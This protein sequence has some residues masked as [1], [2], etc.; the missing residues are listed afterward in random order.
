MKVAYPKCSLDYRPSK[1]REV[2]TEK[3]GRQSSVTNWSAWT[4]RKRPSGVKMWMTLD[5]GYGAVSFFQETLHSPFEIAGGFGGNHVEHDGGG[6]VEEA[7][8]GAGG[9]LVVEED[10]EA[11][12]AGFVVRELIHGFEV[13]QTDGVL[14]EVAN[15]DDVCIGLHALVRVLSVAHGD[16]FSVDQLVAL[17]FR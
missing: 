11:G 6:E 15:E 17:A 13:Y 9:D 3:P 16:D 1:K 4:A 7:V 10:G 12:L 5:S 14:Q 8:R 2:G